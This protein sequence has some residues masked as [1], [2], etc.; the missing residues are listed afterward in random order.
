MTNVEIQLNQLLMVTKAIAAGDDKHIDDLLA[1]TVLKKSSATVRE[2]AEAISQLIVQK[3]IREFRLE[4]MIED[5][6]TAQAQVEKSKLDPLTKLPNRGLFHEILDGLCSENK[7]T[8]G[9]VA[10]MFIDLD[11]FKQVNDSLGH[12]AGDEILIQ[13]SERMLGC[14]KDTDTLARLGGDEFTIIL[15]GLDSEGTAGEIGERIIAEMSNP[16]DLAEG[17][18]NIGASIGISF[19]PTEAETAVALIK[20][21]DVAMYH[22][23]ESGRNNLKFYRGR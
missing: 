15:P 13:A 10:L 18:A 4:G 17:R 21:A 12:A 16:F 22:A 9:L 2:L 8:E 7:A 23:I 14:L 5:L 6:L 3:E 11:K 1:L 20:N 19:F